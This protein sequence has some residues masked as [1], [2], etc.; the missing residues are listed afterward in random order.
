METSS[1]DNNN[2]KRNRGK[3]GCSRVVG[4]TVS[5][6]ALCRECTGY[7]HAHYVFRTD[8]TEYRTRAFTIV[9]LVGSKPEKEVDLMDSWGLRKKGGFENLTVVTSGH[10]N[11]F[12]FRQF[13]LC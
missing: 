2:K 5:L 10:D 8:E 12:L 7:P 3:G 6:R 1:E 4:V 9:Y 11:L 13:F